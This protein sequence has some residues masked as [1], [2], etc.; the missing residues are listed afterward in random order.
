MTKNGAKIK[1]NDIKSGLCNAPKI[2]N[3]SHCALVTYRISHVLTIYVGIQYSVHCV[4]RLLY[5]NAT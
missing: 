4:V 1:K 3:I 2:A 5:K